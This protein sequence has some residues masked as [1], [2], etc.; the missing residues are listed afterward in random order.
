MHLNVSVHANPH[1]K[2]RLRRRKST[3]NTRQ[4]YAQMRNQKVQVKGRCKVKDA[5]MRNLI[6]EKRWMYTKIDAKMY[7]ALID[8]W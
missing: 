6:I 2:T 3:L 1:L 8:E 4:N 5:K 7:N